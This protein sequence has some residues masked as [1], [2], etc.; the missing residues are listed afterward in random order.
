MSYTLGD[1]ANNL[2][3]WGV[4]WET[5]GEVCHEDYLTKFMTKYCLLE[6][7]MIMFFCV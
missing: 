5:V 4:L 6:I 1:W 3:F 7:V 2:G